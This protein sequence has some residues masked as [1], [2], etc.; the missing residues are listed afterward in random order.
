MAL[1]AY[2]RDVSPTLAD[3]E[4]THLEREPLDVARAAAE[5]HAY[6]AL[7]SQLGATVSRLP[8][9]PGLPDA[10]FVEDTAVVLDEIAVI[11]RPG[12]VSRRPETSSVAAALAAHRP[13]A[14]IEG[15]A[16]LDGGDVLV[17]GRRLYVG[18]STRS[19]RTAI[20]QLATLLRPFDYEVVAV[21]F[22]GCLHLKSCV[23]QVG[24]SL[25]LLNPAWVDPSVFAGCGTVA[26]DPAEPY[27]GNAL[28]LGGAVIHSQHFPR[29]R[30][31]LEAAG[32]RV[33]PIALT[34]LAKAEAGV[35]CCSLLVRGN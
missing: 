29:T 11:T 7:L 17:V 33:R 2:T 23:T 22:S 27:A 34:E 19:S 24:E 25:L 13:L 21:D 30:A 20:E 28:A 16:T 12:A 10:V 8:A 1:I 14:R 32:L 6:E 26:V 31:R 4:L 35:T 18:L 5:H 9:E 15:P 3:C